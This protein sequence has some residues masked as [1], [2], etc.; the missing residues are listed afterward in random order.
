[1][2]ILAARARF[3]FVIVSLQ[4]SIFD[5]SLCIKQPR[6]PVIAEVSARII[7]VADSAEVVKA[8]VKL[9]QLR[10][11]EIAQLPPVWASRKKGRHTATKKSPHGFKSI[12][13]PAS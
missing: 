4:P 7:L 12:T 5:Y 8:W 9:A 10:R 6:C 1:M 11:L 3:D 13:L 2:P